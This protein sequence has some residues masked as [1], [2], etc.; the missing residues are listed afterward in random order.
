MYEDKGGR[1]SAESVRRSLS[2]IYCAAS[3]YGWV[4][5]RVARGGSIARLAI[6]MAAEC[7]VTAMELSAETG[8]TL[9]TVRPILSKMVSKG[10][11]AKSSAMA[12]LY[13]VP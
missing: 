12:G 3:R 9:E 13:I 2:A 8:K 7:G 5:C 4:K 1:T 11:L 6:D 10:K